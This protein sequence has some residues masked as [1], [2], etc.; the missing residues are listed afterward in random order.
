MKAITVECKKTG[1]AKLMDIPEPGALEGSVLV[2]AL[3]W[4]ERMSKLLRVR[5]GTAR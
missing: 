5:L 4:A 3:P 2:E 1:T